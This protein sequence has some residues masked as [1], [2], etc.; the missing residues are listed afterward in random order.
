[1]LRCILMNLQGNLRKPVVEFWFARLQHMELLTLKLKVSF[2]AI[3]CAAAAHGAS[4]IRV[5]AACFWMLLAFPHLPRAAIK[6]HF[7][8][9]QRGNWF[10][11]PFQTMMY[12]AACSILHFAFAKVSLLCDAPLGW[13]LR[14]GAASPQPAWDHRRRCRRNRAC[15][16]PNGARVFF[17]N[18]HRYQAT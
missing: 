1:M 17:R 7:A 12:C 14:D 16:W 8:K 3:A 2:R 10:Q 6:M 11:C 13:E 15:H 5:G 18:Y 4:I 9:S